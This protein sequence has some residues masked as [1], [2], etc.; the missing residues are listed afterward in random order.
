[1]RPL[2]TSVPVLLLAT[3]AGLLAL[4]APARS[5]PRPSR[6]VVEA[7]A[8]YRAGVA[9]Y[10]R[11][12]LD[13]AIRS[14]Q[15]AYELD[16]APILLYNIAQSYRKKGESDQAVLFYRRYLEADPQTRNRAR[17]LSRIDELE[18]R[19]TS[20]SLAAAAATVASPAAPV[21]PSPSPPPRAALSPAPPVRSAAPEVHAPTAAPAPL[22]SAVA[23]PADDE[24]PI[25][26]RPWFWGAVAGALIVAATAV[27]LSS[28]GGGGLSC[29][30][31]NA[32]SVSVPTR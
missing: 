32:P 7:K 16:P 23:R 24:R 26:G 28:R 13:E 1:V 19:R 3:L 21:A 30:D 10:E 27:V 18:G 31:C 8:R 6:D 20:A 5:E 9:A 11:G 15:R 4:P 17:V 25:Y 2:G 12:L 14:F 29:S 22:M